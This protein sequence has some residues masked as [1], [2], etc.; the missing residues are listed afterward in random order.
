MAGSTDKYL[1]QFDWLQA[2]GNSNRMSAVHYSWAQSDVPDTERAKGI[3]SS[4]EEAENNQWWI[5]TGLERG[6]EIYSDQ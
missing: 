2:A 5:R 1:L 4:T 3:V 6:E